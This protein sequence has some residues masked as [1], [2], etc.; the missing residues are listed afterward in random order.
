MAAGTPVVAFQTSGAQEFLHIGACLLVQETSFQAMA[1]AILDLSQVLDCTALRTPS[2][3]I[4]CC[5]I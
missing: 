5:R 3:T 2:L 4:L 1:E